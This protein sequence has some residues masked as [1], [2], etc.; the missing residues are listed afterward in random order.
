[1]TGVWR[2]SK[3]KYQT[4][5]SVTSSPRVAALGWTKHTGKKAQ[6]AQNRRDEVERNSKKI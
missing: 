2:P 6:T 3:R 4:A 1:M 5:I